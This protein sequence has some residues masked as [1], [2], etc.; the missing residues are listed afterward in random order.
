MTEFE[1]LLSEIIDEFLMSYKVEKDR[2]DFTIFKERELIETYAH[3][4]ANMVNRLPI[5]TL[6]EERK[7][8]EKIHKDRRHNQKCFR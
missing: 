8:Y 2:D 6:T 1:Y 7:N 3:I 4:I 5:E